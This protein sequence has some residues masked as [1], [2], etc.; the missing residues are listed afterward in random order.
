MTTHSPPHPGTQIQ[1]IITSLALTVSEA[2]R[3]LD[4]PRVTLS[5]VIHGRHPV[6]AAIALRLHRWL[7]KPTAAHWMKQQAQYDLWREKHIGIRLAVAGNNFHPDPVKQHL[8]EHSGDI[9]KKVPIHGLPPLATQSRQVCSS[10]RGRCGQRS[11]T[12]ARCAADCTAS[13]KGSSP[14]RI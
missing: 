9:F 7:G 2:A 12:N 5:R 11:A 4:I 6:N 10:P 1:T 3:Q 8:G 14:R 13:C